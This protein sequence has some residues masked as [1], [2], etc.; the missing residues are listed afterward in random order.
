MRKQVFCQSEHVYVCVC[1]AAR[2]RENRLTLCSHSLGDIA[3][4]LR[5]LI[6]AVKKVLFDG[7]DFTQSYATCCATML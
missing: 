6:D 7:V 2:A 3:I 5:K 1:V 4:S